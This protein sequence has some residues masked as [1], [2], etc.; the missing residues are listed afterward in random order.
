MFERKTIKVK[1]GHIFFLVCKFTNDFEYLIRKV[2]AIISLFFHHVWLD[3]EQ[4]LSYE[5]LQ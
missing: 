1:F 5:T 2:K 4:D 3:E